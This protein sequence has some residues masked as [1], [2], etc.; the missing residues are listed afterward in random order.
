MREMNRV[1]APSFRRAG[2]PSHQD[3][4]ILSNGLCAVHSGE[5]SRADWNFGRIE[6]IGFVGRKC[7]TSEEK[8]D[9]R[10]ARLYLLSAD[11]RHKQGNVAAQRAG[12]YR[13]SRKL[14][15]RSIK[16]LQASFVD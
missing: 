6:R 7:E 11:S 15:A 10:L 14:P 4:T 8:V 13:S 5:E 1:D 16:D 12:P 3:S 2:L 9:D